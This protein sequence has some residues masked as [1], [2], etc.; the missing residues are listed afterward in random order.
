MNRSWFRSVAA[1]AVVACLA[2]AGVVAETVNRIVATV[3]GDPVTLIELQKF[4]AEA[5]ALPT[6]QQSGVP[7][8]DERA[9]LD[10]LVLDR[11]LQKEIEA[12]GLTASDQQIDTY[13]RQIRERNNLSEG[14]L[15]EVLSQQGISWE[16][17]REQ[18]RGDIE[19]ANLI[20]KE[21]RS[22]VNV[23]PEEIQRYHE[24][25]PGSVSAAGSAAKPAAPKASTAKAHT[26][27]ISIMVERGSGSAE[28]EAARAKAEKIHA[29]AVDG[30]DFAELAREH[31]QGPGAA[32]GGDLGD[33]RPSDMQPEF[34]KA[35]AGLKPGQVSPV[36]ENAAG[37]HILR[38]DEAE[39][40]E[41]EVVE[42]E[43]EVVEEGELTDAQ[44]D[45]IREKLY[46][47]AIEE[48]YDRW[49]KQDLR[50]RHHVEI[51]L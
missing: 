28:R 2:P 27:L 44:K 24:A 10:Q 14:Q 9:M 39:G 13:I 20:N 4:M 35:A 16:A 8:A 34:E 1:L 25:N 50:A 12:G 36:I 49:L 38:I 19:R 33:I 32:E 45:E 21:I 6:A 18:V 48:R 40:G 29:E 31:S 3:D 7:I 37:F 5:Q 46:K 42:E 22:K 26:R 23:S 17:Y 47:Q 30:G 15:K 43:T 51:L 11:I 41:E